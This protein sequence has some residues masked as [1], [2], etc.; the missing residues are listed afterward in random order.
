M[1]RKIV[2]LL[3]ALLATLALAG[4]GTF[5]CD[6][7]GKEKSGK[8]YSVTILDEKATICEDCHD[9]INAIKDAFK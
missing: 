3:T 8:S 7:C 5:T 1:K 4:C 9:G 6:M 2:L